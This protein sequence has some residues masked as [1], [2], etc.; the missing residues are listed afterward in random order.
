MNLIILII[1]ALHHHFT[2]FY[3]KVVNKSKTVYRTVYETNNKTI[4]IVPC[5]TSLSTETTTSIST[6][7]STSTDKPSTTTTDTTTGP[8][9][10]SYITTD[11]GRYV[12]DANRQRTVVMNHLLSTVFAIFLFFFI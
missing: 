3:S 12:N 4:I 7:S 11:V 6:S 10:I 2:I 9:T 5:T 1:L 8:C